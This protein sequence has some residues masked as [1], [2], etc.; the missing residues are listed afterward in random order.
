[1]RFGD[2]LDDWER[3]TAIPGGLKEA[4][5]AEERLKREE[6]ESRLDHE[7][8][9]DGPVRDSLLSWL[10][11]HGVEDK[12]GLGPDLADRQ[13]REKEARRI[14]DLRPQA[15][16]DLHGYS[17]ADAE[18]ALNAFLEGAARAGLEKVLVVTGK[19]VHSKG[20]PVLGKT[21]RHVLE[22]SPFAGRFGVADPENG[23]SGALW[24]IVRKGS[25]FSR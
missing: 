18:K 7:R 6:A 15:R 3:K 14:R 21:A 10:D 24:V 22:A 13:E 4:V 2:I 12:D 16:L 1:M 23:G 25:Y 8:E 17:A 5:K 9:K 20:E 19:G 11:D